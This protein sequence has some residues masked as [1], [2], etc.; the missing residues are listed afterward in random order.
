MG[1]GR[2]AAGVPTSSTFRR[3]LHS[4]FIGLMLAV[5]LLKPVLSLDCFCADMGHRDTVASAVAG[6]DD[7]C[8]GQDCH[9]CCAHVTAVVAPVR[10]LPLSTAGAQAS[11]AAVSSHRARPPLGVFRPPIAG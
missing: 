2:Y 8:P 3:R 5:L 10:L 7:C 6:G 4:L 1:Q 9:D 11:V